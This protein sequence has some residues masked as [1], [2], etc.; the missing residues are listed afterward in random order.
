M[1]MMMMMMMMMLQGHLAQENTAVQTLLAGF[2][3]QKVIF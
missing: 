2:D 3:Q 1:M